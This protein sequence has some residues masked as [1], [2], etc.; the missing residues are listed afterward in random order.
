MLLSPGGEF[1]GWDET[2]NAHCPDRRC[3]HVLVGSREPLPRRER[4]GMALSERDE[5]SAP[6]GS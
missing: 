4:E 5:L 6:I 2:A 1:A 3:E